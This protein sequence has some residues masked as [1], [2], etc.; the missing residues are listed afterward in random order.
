MQ[1]P[2]A[3]HAKVAHCRSAAPYIAI[4]VLPWIAVSD[5]SA[6]VKARPAWISRPTLK[7]LKIRIFSIFVSAIW[8]KARPS[9]RFRVG[10]NIS[11]GNDIGW[12]Q[13]LLTE[14][15]LMMAG[16]MLGL[17]SSE[18]NKVSSQGECI[19]WQKWSPL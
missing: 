3:H 17:C 1:T 15:S 7:P 2:S 5:H 6:L 9:I 19:F 16:T 8:C 4:T 18:Y 12:I 10:L 13:V 11:L 14:L